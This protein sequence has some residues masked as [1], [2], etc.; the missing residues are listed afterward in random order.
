MC[1]LPYFL[2]LFLSVPLSPTV[3]LSLSFIDVDK[4]A[5]S[6]LSEDAIDK[7]KKATD[8]FT[9]IKGKLVH[10]DI[11]INLLNIILQHSDAFLELLQI[12]NMKR[13]TE[14]QML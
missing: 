8:V 11:K 1:E 6:K 10:G 9:T 13:R 4:N 3:S 14:T 7:I 2:C 5:T 12:G